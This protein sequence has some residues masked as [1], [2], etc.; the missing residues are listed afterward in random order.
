MNGFADALA[1]AETHVAGIIDRVHARDHTV[2]QDDPTEVAD[3]LGWLDA[4]TAFTAR[5]GELEAHARALRSD[6]VDR[7]VLLGMGGS[8]LYPEVLARVFGPQPDGLELAVLDTT[9]PAAVARALAT[10]E[11]SRTVVV[12]A[13]KSGGTIETRTLFEA[14]VDVLRAALGDRAGDH[15][16]T[17]TDPGSA[18]VAMGDELGFRA[19]VENPADIGG[20]FAALSAFGMLP[21]ALL[22]LDVAAHLAPGVAMVASTRAAYA[23][24]PAARLGA[25]LGA[26]MRTGRFA[27]TL[28]L[29][30]PLAPLGDWIE[31]LVAESTGKG[32]QGLLPVIDE[33]V[34][35]A[36]GDNRV[37]VVHGDAA[38]PDGVP[39]FR[40][41]DVGAD[42]MAGEVVRWEFA[43]A[44][45]S[46]VVGQNPFDQPDVQSAKSATAAVLEQD[47]DP[48][49]VPD[50]AEELLA[51]VDPT[52]DA[53]AILAYLDPD[54]AAA[55]TL[56]DVVTSLR[57]RLPGVPVTTGIGPR[58]LHS[59][60]QFH[61]GGPDRVAFLLVVDPTDTT[62]V[63][64]P[65]RDLGFRKLFR[66]QAAGDLAAL[67]DAGRRVAVVTL[68]ELTDALER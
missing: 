12:P 33:P 55:A 32:G 38:V 26:A 3:R 17:I 28:H 52:V 43:T 15:V 47:G 67:R 23:D 39:V 49:L 44:I 66:G 40:L 20:R 8:S 4:P 16:I 13:S 58:Y 45:A 63:P 41:P 46:A 14:H 51:T 36:Y 35:A 68:P 48:V 56:P 65:G 50:S 10:L 18:L 6:G 30:A 57:D 7:A 27:L 2:W 11:P 54:G 42:D 60:G 37:L 1:A 21:A 31:Q 22:G 9:N 53:V 64:I 59:T 61:K 34:S 24:N 25:F 19:V 29:P 62:D 5:A